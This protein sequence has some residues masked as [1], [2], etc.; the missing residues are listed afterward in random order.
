[1]VG[2][3]RRLTGKTG[4]PRSC[5]F[6]RQR[7]PVEIQRGNV[8]FIAGSTPSIKGL[9]KIILLTLAARAQATVALIDAFINY[10]VWVI[11]LLDDELAT[12]LLVVFIRYL[13]PAFA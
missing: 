10:I 2:I 13:M 11:S 7:I 1:M 8:A 4:D 3:G 12:N 6:L 9:D 5:P